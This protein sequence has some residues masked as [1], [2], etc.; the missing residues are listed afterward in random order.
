[1]TLNGL[2][3]RFYRITLVG[4]LAD[5]LAMVRL[6][7]EVSGRKPQK[8]TAAFSIYQGYKLDVFN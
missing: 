5:I 3:Q 2:N 1:M 8:S 7:L 4:D 6:G